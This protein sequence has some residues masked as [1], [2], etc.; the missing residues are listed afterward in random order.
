MNG[1]EVCNTLSAAVYVLCGLPIQLC[2]EHRREFWVSLCLDDEIKSISSKH[3]KLLLEAEGKQSSKY[4]P[5]YV[6]K[7]QDELI[8]AKYDA[9]TMVKI[10][11]W[12]KQ[13]IGKYRDEK[14]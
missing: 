5:Q 9:D 6:C 7:M 14:K 8:E 3:D 13:W 2:H 1:C 10:N 12:I 11:N 4:T